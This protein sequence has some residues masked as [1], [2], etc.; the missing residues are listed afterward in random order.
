MGIL[1][2]SHH[3]QEI[4]CKLNPHVTS[5]TGGSYETA[6]SPSALLTRLGWPVVCRLHK[7]HLGNNRVVLLAAHNQL[8]GSPR[9]VVRLLHVAHRHVLL[10]RGAECATGH[11]SNLQTPEFM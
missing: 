5:A 9:L 10:Q 11:L 3:T 6:G 8:Q 4:P 2:P 7:G 1:A